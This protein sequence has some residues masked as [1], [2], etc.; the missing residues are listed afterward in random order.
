MITG[1]TGTLE[2][3]G[4]DWVQVKVGGGVS[5]QIFVPA[6][7][8]LELG[9]IGEVVRLHTRLYIRDD[10]AVLYG[11]T[12]PDA[13]RLF[14]MLTGVSGIGPRTSL[15]ILSTLG[16]QSLI[17]AVATED[18][19]TLSKVPGVGR[20]SAGRL[21][22]ELKSRLEKGA[23]GSAGPARRHRCRRRGSVGA[24][25]LGLLR[26]RVP[27]GGDLHE[28]YRQ[29]SPGREDTEGI[30]ADRGTLIHPP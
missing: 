27:P 6:S 18:L 7:A 5:I 22:L 1:I 30:A 16:T 25:G 13:L 12:S 19:S 21:V 23:N 2:A 14:Q 4:Q 3:T 17:N 29:P 8:I 10:E 11:F 15:A 26:R 9:D 24:D 20:K 28:R